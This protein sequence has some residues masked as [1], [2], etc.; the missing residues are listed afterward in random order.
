MGIAMI[1]MNCDKVA[2]NIILRPEG[3][4]CDGSATEHAVGGPFLA[5]LASISQH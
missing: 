1:A 4:L 5:T 2:M 3:S